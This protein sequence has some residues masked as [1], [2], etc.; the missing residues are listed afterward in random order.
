MRKLKIAFGM[1]VFQSDYVLKQCL[2][3]VYPFA[4]QIVIAEGCVEYWQRKGFT[5]S[6]DRTNEIL[7]NFPDP[8]NKITIIHNVYK[9]K[10][11]QCQAYMKYIR[12]DIDYVWHLDSDEIY[13]TEDLERMESILLKEGATSIG[14]RS[15][16]FYGGFSR[17]LTGFELKFD[18]RRIF[19]YIPGCSW[20]THRPP[21]IK[22]PTQIKERHI[23]PQEFYDKY[24]IQIYHYSYVFPDQVHNKLQYYKEEIVKNNCIDNYF[25]EIYLPWVVGDD[26]IKEEIENRYLGVHE[27][28]PKI[29][30]E[31]RT[32]KFE[33]IHPESIRRDLSK[34]KL[35]FDNQLKKYK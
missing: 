9:E 16:A 35:E 33:G 22:Y 5:T 1:I 10:D 18:F 23:T 21:T 6:T 17:H 29:R 4:E 25:N 31:C 19:K 27:T 24:G 28:K 12:K 3:Q 30:G 14:L 11:Q 34:L 20:L 7:H 32:A 13:K 15:F 26:K 8:E 2:E